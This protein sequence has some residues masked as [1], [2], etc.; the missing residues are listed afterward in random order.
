[1]SNYVEVTANTYSVQELKNMEGRV[2]SALDF[3]LNTITPLSILEATQADSIM[4]TKMSPNVLSLC[5][6]II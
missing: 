3:E 6:Y 1:M 2:M 4:L 5:K